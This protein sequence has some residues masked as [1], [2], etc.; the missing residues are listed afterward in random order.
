MSEQLVDVATAAQRLG[1]TKSSIYR[2]VKSGKIPAFSA[3]PLQTG[4]R[5]DIQEVREAIR[6]RSNNAE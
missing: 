4:I 3:G 1:M 6:K 2:L 5:L